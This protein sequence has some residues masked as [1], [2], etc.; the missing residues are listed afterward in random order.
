[1]TKEKEI[2]EL[3]PLCDLGVSSC[4]CDENEVGK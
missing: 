1:M 3:C 2:E 4:L